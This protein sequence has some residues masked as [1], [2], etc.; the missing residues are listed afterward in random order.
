MA[1]LSVCSGITLWCASGAAWLRAPGSDGKRW[2][3]DDLTELTELTVEAYES[4]AGAA[5]AT[6][7]VAAAGSAGAPRLAEVCTSA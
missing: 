4:T 1:V 7:T 5:A 3:Y 6:G 2:S